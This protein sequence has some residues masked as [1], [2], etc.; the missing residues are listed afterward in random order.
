MS[1]F[2]QQLKH[3]ETGKEQKAFCIDDYFG[4][5]RYGYFF[6]KDGTDVD[7]KDFNK[8]QQQPPM[9]FDIFNEDSFDIFN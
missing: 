4:Q 1:S 5:H 2:I 9:E 3:P 8:L 7:W 6:K